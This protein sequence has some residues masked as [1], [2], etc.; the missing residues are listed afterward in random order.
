MF[1]WHD[2]K[3]CL[4]RLVTVFYL[5]GNWREGFDAIN[6]ADH[7]ICC[8][9]R[10]GASLLINAPFWIDN[11]TYPLIDCLIRWVFIWSYIL[12]NVDHMLWWVHFHRSSWNIFYLN[13]CWFKLAIRVTY[14]MRSLFFPSYFAT[15]NVIKKSFQQISHSQTRGYARELK[16]WFQFQLTETSEDKVKKR[17]SSEFLMYQ[18]DTKCCQKPN[19]IIQTRGS[20]YGL[21]CS[22]LTSLHWRCLLCERCHLEWGQ[23]Y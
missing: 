13:C 16:V 3:I 15:R 5:G 23:H 12:R 4:M 19:Y 22:L 1:L 2:I 18:N 8:S 10:A 11:A 7:Q 9:Q 20:C 21:F 6:S 17:T 14:T